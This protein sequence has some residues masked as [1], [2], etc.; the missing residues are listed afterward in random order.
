MLYTYISL[1]LGIVNRWKD[2]VLIVFLIKNCVM[3]TYYMPG[4]MI[5]AEIEIRNKE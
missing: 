5:C 2:R 3:S 4:T 1:P